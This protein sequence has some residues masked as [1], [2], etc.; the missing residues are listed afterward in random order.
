MPTPD[1]L[2]K[3]LTACLSVSP[4]VAY[5]LGRRYENVILIG[6]TGSRT[7]LCCSERTC[8]LAY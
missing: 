5:N 4:F 7:M 6:L 8:R 2:Y 1:K 3:R